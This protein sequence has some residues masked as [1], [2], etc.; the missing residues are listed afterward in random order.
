MLFT[1]LFLPLLVSLGF[2]QLER[3]EE[4]T[5]QLAQWED[6]GNTLDWE[7]YS[8]SGLQPGQPVTTTGRYRESIWL[9][10]NRTRDG[11]PGYEVLALFEPQQ[12]DALVVNRG[13]IQAPRRRDELPEI[14]TPPNVVTLIGRLSDYP[15]PPVLMETA[16]DLT[17]WPRRVQALTRS[18]VAALGVDA[19][20]LVM[21]LADPDQPGAYR[22]DWSPDYMGTQ[23]HYGYAVQWFALALV[24]IISTVVASYRKNGK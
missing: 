1:G 19:P 2:W 13:W 23:T 5:E 14:S 3:A 4:K 11:A 15:E 20:S 7:T 8:G 16:T 24:L 17:Q 12:G 22:A 9:L 18:D 21:R 6:P 10:D